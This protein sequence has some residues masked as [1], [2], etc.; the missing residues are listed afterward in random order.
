MTKDKSRPAQSSPAAALTQLT[1]VEVKTHLP[2]SGAA[3]GAGEIREVSSEWT[4]KDRVGGW[5]VRWGIGRNSYRV[6][7]GLY[8][9]GEPDRQ[10][11]VLVS[12][13]YKLS[14]DVL[15]RAMA[16]RKAWI[17]VLDSDGINVWC[18]A[19]KGTLGTEELVHRI[20][21]TNLPEAVDHRKLIVPQLGAVGI[22]AH[23]VKKH[24]G[25][26][27]VF[28]PV[29]A[30]DIPRFLDSGFKAD[31]TMRTVTFTLRER[32]VL[33]PM[34]LV[35]AM[36]YAVPVLLLLVLFGGFGRWGYSTEALLRNGASA[37]AALA[38]A[39]L[40]GAVITPLLLPW[41]PGRSFSTKGFF[42]G[43]AWA[44]L[45][46]FPAGAFLP[47]T[48]NLSAWET[49]AWVLALPALS[50]F[51]SMNFTGSSTVTSLSGVRKEMRY[52]FPLQAIGALGGLLLWVAGH[53]LGGQA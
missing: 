41:L 53:F 6:R 43:L 52:A 29:R 8:A 40:A 7:P 30:G 15:R 39:L 1:V 21:A 16:G 14:F 37:A 36:R 12:A 46:V 23:E 20:R 35:P 45:F 32:L 17:L 47:E 10:S 48:A 34:E 44:L 4:L 3:L 38:G 22:A 24:S 2:P 19:G 13:N 50:A 51:L 11:P 18:A 26:R 49:A 9:L 28:G 42:P 31:S 33:V 27:V 25:F 5:K